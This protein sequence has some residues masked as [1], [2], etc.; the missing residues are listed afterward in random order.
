M[1][2]TFVL[3]FSFLAVA[4]MAWASANSVLPI[5]PSRKAP[6]AMSVQLAKLQ[7]YQN[8]KDQYAATRS[9]AASSTTSAF[10]APAPAPSQPPSPSAS[11]PPNSTPAPV[12]A[13]APENQNPPP[14]ASNPSNPPN[15]PPASSNQ[16]DPNSSQTSQ[17]PSNQNP[18][19]TNG[20]SNT[21]SSSSAQEGDRVV[22]AG[23]SPGREIY[24]ANQDIQGRQ[25]NVGSKQ[26]VARPVQNVLGGV[27]Q[28]CPPY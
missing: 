19:Q 7:N 14:S 27:V 4:S 18:P 10:P 15:P 26:D 28:R 23:K 1:S 21:T 25:I 17:A 24:Q 20:S 3:V 12:P 2:R 9:P 22:V 11:N 16:N 6:T 13:P 8:L 5:K